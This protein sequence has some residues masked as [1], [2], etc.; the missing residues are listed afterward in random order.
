MIKYLLA[1]VSAITL[2]G[3]ASLLQSVGSPIASTSV[4]NWCAQN[5]EHCV[6]V[7]VQGGTLSAD[8]AT[9]KVT[10]QR[11]SRQWIVWHLDTPGYQFVNQPGNRPITFKAATSGQFDPEDS[12]RCYLFNSLQVFVCIDMNTQLGMF[13]Y[14]IKVTGTP[15]VPQ[16]DPIIV[17]N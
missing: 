6:T 16:L 8:P 9:V 1:G 17:N 12:A 5:T 7:T 14:G 15:Q 2:T 13:N 10:G 11:G 4:S 3:C